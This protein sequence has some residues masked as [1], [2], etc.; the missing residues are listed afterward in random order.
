MWIYGFSEVLHKLK[1]WASKRDVCV[2]QLGVD[3]DDDG[4]CD[5]AGNPQQAAVWR[6]SLWAQRADGNS[7]DY[8]S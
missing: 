4:L 3:D 6:P 1:I 8:L 2:Y 7:M 5:E